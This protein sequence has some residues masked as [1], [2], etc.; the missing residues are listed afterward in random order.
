MGSEMCIRDRVE[1]A[2]L[3][4]SNNRRRSPDFAEKFA[5]YS[6]EAIT[7][8]SSLGKVAREKFDRPASTESLPFAASAVSSI[9]AP[10]GSLRAISCNKTAETVV[11]PVRSTLACTRSTISTSKSV[12]L[13]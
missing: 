12:A 11:E 5:A 1:I 7:G 6:D 9:S 4:L 13:N 2:N 3:D 8:K 10:S